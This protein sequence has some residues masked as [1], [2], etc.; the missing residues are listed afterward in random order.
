MT[1]TPITPTETSAASPQVPSQA[2][3]EEALK[4]LYTDLAT[5]AGHSKVTQLQ[6][7]RKRL[8]MNRK[9]NKPTATPMYPAPP[10]PRAGR[11]FGKNVPPPFLVVKGEGK[12]APPP[13]DVSMKTRRVS[14]VRVPTQQQSKGTADDVKTTNETRQRTLTPIPKKPSAASKSTAASKPSK[15]PSVPVP[16]VTQKLV[17]PPIPQRT[18]G[19]EVSG[20]QGMNQPE[21]TSSRSP[22][23][24]PL[25]PIKAKRKPK[26]ASV[27]MPE[28]A[29]GPKTPGTESTSA[30]RRKPKVQEPEKKIQPN[31]SP[32]RTRGQRVLWAERARV[33]PIAER[34]VGGIKGTAFSRTASVGEGTNYLNMAPVSS[35]H[36]AHAVHIIRYRRVQV[37]SHRD[38]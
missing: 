18:R 17:L 8:G 24:R 38:F 4:M 1:E 29:E 30:G 14:S 32:E 34:E 9:D 19:G 36:L 15:L 23:R 10:P 2:E 21:K 35:P 11:R 12:P 22:V 27:P 6:S 7:Q 37:R 26:A 5:T 16:V 31:R 20:V 3:V 28:S 25:G 13:R 33:K